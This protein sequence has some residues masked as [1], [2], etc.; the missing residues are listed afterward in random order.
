MSSTSTANS[1]TDLELLKKIAVGDESAFSE[2][3]SRY[4]SSLFNF[5]LRLILRKDAAEDVLQEVFL[6]V[7]QGSNRFQ[8]KSAVKT[9]LFRIAYH[10]SISWLR[11]EK[12]RLQ[13]LNIDELSIF[14]EKPSP[15]GSL[16][17]HWQETQ[18]KSAI[19]QLSHNHRS[20]IELTFVHGFSYKEIANIM[21]CPVGTVKSRM[22]YALRYLRTNLS[23]NASDEF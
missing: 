8:S 16:I 21:K 19:A 2:L 4:N 18:I 17:D 9:W 10:K 3:Y 20:V 12:I 22:N 23:I 1:E 6:A 5:I 13:S 11:K 7:W 15:E 14:S